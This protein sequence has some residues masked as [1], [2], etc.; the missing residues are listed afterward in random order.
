[1]TRAVRL[2]IGL[3]LLM[4]SFAALPAK[5][6]GLGDLFGEGPL[7]DGIKADSA[8][9]VR[10]ALLGDAQPNQRAADGTPALVIAVSMRNFE[11]V[12]LLV[13]QGA[14]IDVASKDGTTP[15]T[16]AAA[17]GDAK[18]VSYLLEKKADV[19]KTGALRESAL[20][21]AVRG[22][23]AEVVKI[24][25]DNGADPNETDQAGNS[26]LEIART[27]RQPAVVEMLEKKGAT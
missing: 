10:G 27:T 6:S 16:L 4:A 2:A 15:L 24:L 11:I 14:R 23:H 21:K 17:N 9:R 12:I 26:V 7:I 25:L 18:I 22:K 19:D 8:E 3:A 1:M 5:A 20:I 13:D